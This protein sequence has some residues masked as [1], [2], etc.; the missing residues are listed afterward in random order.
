MKYILI[1]FLA[2]TACREYTP[3]E[4]SAHRTLKYGDVLDQQ[5]TR[6]FTELHY[7]EHVYLESVS[8]FV[9][10]AEHC[11][12]EHGCSESKVDKEEI[13]RFIHDEIRMKVLSPKRIADA[14]EKVLDK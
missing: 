10:H 3:A 7:E 9:L 4:R 14:L 6:R 2:L 12:A 1:L 13:R 8:G 5:D 11:P